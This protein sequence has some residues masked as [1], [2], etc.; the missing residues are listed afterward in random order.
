MTHPELHLSVASDGKSACHGR[1]SADE[2]VEQSMFDILL[3]A[4]IKCSL[5]VTTALLEHDR[6]VFEVQAVAVKPLFEHAFHLLDARNQR[7]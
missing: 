2:H 1:L 6:T 7:I 5:S 4:A 3:N